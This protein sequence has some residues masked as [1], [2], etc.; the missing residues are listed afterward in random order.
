[1]ITTAIVSV[2]FT[3]VPSHTG[4]GSR[5]SARHSDRPGGLHSGIARRA[6]G[7]AVCGHNPALRPPHAPPSVLAH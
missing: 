7:C 1:M 6:P 2:P 4:S 5:L 3:A